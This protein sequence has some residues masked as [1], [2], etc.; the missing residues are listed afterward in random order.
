MKKAL[1]IT[2]ALVLFWGCSVPH[3]DAYVP[4][5]RNYEFVGAKNAATPGGLR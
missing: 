2:A 3:I 5:Q 4:K 1:L